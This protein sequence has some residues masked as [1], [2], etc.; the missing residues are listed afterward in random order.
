MILKNLYYNSCVHLAVAYP[1]RGEIIEY[2]FS[3]Q[4]DL[5]NMSDNNEYTTLIYGN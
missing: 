3:K 2:L 5:I 1:K 4:K